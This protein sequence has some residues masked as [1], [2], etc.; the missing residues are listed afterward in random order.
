MIKIPG[1]R[2][3]KKDYSQTVERVAVPSFKI[4]EKGFAMQAD[5]GVH[6][7]DW[8]SLVVI[9]EALFSDLETGKLLQAK[10]VIVKEIEVSCYDNILLDVYAYRYNMITGEFN[11]IFDVQFY[12]NLKL[13]LVGITCRPDEI[14]GFR[15]WNQSSLTTWV[16][17][18]LSGVAEGPFVEAE[19]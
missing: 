16:S 19:Y 18:Y 1:I 4:E 11:W 9:D 7:N 6:P 5:T 2:I 17:M 13:S 15:V 14:I 10:R 8:A 12:N 3:G